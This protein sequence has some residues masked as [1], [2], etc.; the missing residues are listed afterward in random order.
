VTALIATNVVFGMASRVYVRKHLCRVVYD[1]TSSICVPA[2]GL[3]KQSPLSEEL[4]TMR[5]QLC[6]R[7][8]WV[9]GLLTQGCQPSICLSGLVLSPGHHEG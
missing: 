4:F 3:T 7:A 9:A 8:Y 2:Q 1:V 6:Q 5:T